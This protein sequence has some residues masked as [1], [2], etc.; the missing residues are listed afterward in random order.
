MRLVALLAVWTLSIGGAHTRIDPTILPGKI[1]FVGFNHA[2]G[3]AA[4]QHLYVVHANGTEQQKLLLDYSSIWHLTSYR[5]LQKL[6]FTSSSET[7]SRNG[8]F[9]LDVHEPW[10]EGQL[11]TR[12]HRAL[13]SEFPVKYYSSIVKGVYY[14]IAFSPDGKS[15]AGMADKGWLHIA[16]VETGTATAVEGQAVSHSD[17]PAWSP[18]GSR[19]VFR[20]CVFDDP[21]CNDVELFIVDAS[22]K[23]LRQLTNLPRKYSWWS[24]LWMPPSE[25]PKYKTMHKSSL[26]AWS[27]DG[28]WIAFNSFGD[29][30]KIRPDGTGLTLVVKD[31]A[32]PTWSPD[33]KMIAYGAFRRDTP[34]LTAAESPE[35]A[36]Y[37][38]PNIYVRWADGKGETRITN[39]RSRLGYLHLNW[40]E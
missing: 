25:K 11:P 39:N 8:I 38:P 12:L 22:G 36:G 27:P 6:S 18:D 1:F 5:R 31:A 17:G 19:I 28:Q 3:Q 10:K 30:Y 9:V 34:P 35:H 4:T 26:P 40:V 14:D 16:D 32:Y 20:G 7:E 2:Q 13:P 15:V 33:S 24:L 23:N 37:R 21:N 29:I